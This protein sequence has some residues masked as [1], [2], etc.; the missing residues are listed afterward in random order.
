M[1][2]ADA[3]PADAESAVR[4]A[5][6]LV[7][8]KIIDAKQLPQGA[9]RSDAE[10][11]LVK[12]RTRMDNLSLKITQLKVDTSMRRTAVN[13]PREFEQVATA[14]REVKKVVAAA[15][16]LAEDVLEKEIPQKVKDACAAT[17]KVEKAAA[18][19]AVDAR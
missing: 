18:K 13:L 7:M 1:G 17:L 14:E 12:L 10:E 15:G 2:R 16:P 9:M 3:L 19:F 8:E 6:T 11:E 4:L 5:R